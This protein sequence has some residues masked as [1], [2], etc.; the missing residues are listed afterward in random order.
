MEG[1]QI[2]R[3]SLNIDQETKN[4]NFNWHGVT[5]TL[6]RNRVRHILP[7]PDI[8]SSPSQKNIGLGQ[9]WSAQTIDTM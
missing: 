2:G 9:V 4:Y 3:F 5:L 1:D 8:M 7:M 6:S